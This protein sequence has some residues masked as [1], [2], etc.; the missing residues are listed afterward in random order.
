MNRNNVEEVT[1][2]VMHTT[3]SKI[4]D[5]INRVIYEW[6]IM[7]VVY[8]MMYKLGK[9]HPD[10]IVIRSLVDKKDVDS[11]RNNLETAFPGLCIFNPPMAV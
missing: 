6:S 10:K 2:L 1:V 7:E 3:N 8:P 9:D 4:I 11:L 5:S